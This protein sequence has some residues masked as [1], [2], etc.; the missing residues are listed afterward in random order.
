MDMQQ[1]NVPEGGYEI[2]QFFKS[3]HLR[4]PLQEVSQPFETMAHHLAQTLPRCAET[5]TAL[6]KLLEAKDAAVRAKI[7]AGPF[8]EG[9]KG[10]NESW[11]TEA[12]EGGLYPEP[13]T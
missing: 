11:P 12:R 4:A 9:M 8:E 10:G 3:G 6:R 13:P 5:S 1:Q 2:L 7:L